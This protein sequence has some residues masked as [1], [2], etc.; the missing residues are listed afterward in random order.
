MTIQNLVTST[1]HSTTRCPPPNAA[2]AVSRVVD[3]AVALD[4]GQVAAARLWAVWRKVLAEGD[5][6]EKV[7]DVF[8]RVML[9]L[10]EFGRS[11]HNFDDMGLLLTFS[12]GEQILMDGC[13][14]S[15]FDQQFEEC[16]RCFFDLCQKALV[17]NKK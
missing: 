11:R 4:E 13:I 12:K 1:M 3:D 5:N 14:R 15:I 8:Q 6:N 10:I 17:D 9:M 2:V 7:F 16:F